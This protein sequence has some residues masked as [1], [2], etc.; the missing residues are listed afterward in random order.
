ML[1]GRNS[2][3]SP[4][5]YGVRGEMLR[6][7]GRRVFTKGREGLKGGLPADEIY[8]IQS[9]VFNPKTKKRRL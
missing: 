1:M 3:N 9:T 4:G 8:P 5:H 6:Q 7:V 2:E